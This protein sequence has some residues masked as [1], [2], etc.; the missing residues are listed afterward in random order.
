MVMPKSKNN[1]K[2]IWVNEICIRNLN[3]IFLYSKIKAIDDFFLSQYLCYLLSTSAAKVWDEKFSFLYILNVPQKQIKYVVSNVGHQ[4]NNN[5]LNLN[6]YGIVL[7]FTAII[8]VRKWS[9]APKSHGIQ[10]VHAETEP[11]ACPDAGAA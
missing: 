11:S 7:L 1:V 2:Q 4:S 10:E 5:T 9:V 3:L 6:Y 8:Q